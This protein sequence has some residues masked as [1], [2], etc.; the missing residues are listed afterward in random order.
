MEDQQDQGAG[1]ESHTG[2]RGPPDGDD[3][4]TSSASSS[5]SDLPSSAPEGDRPASRHQSTRTFTG[6]RLFG[7][8]GSF[9]QSSTGPLATAMAVLGCLAQSLFTSDTWK[10]LN[11]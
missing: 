11:H 1:G 2:Q 5:T 10:D 9:F 4:L 7:R 6:L 8:S 3:A